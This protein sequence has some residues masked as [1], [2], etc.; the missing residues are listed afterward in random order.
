MS[1]KILWS[2]V[3]SLVMMGV[4]VC[5]SEPFLMRG[6]RPL[7]MGGA[8]VA[9]AEDASSYWNPAGL[10][11]Q[12]K[13]FD[14]EIPIYADVTGTKD[15]VKE[16]DEIANAGYYSLKQKA[17]T[18][19]YGTATIGTESVKSFFNL[20]NELDDLNK[21]GIGILINAGAG[22]NLRIKKWGLSFN[23]Y[24]MFSGAPSIDLNNISFGKTGTSSVE[25]AKDAIYALVGDGN[26]I[27]GTDTIQSKLAESL[28]KITLSSG[29]G[30]IT[31]NQAEQL[32]QYALNAGLSFD[33]VK[34]Y[35]T[36]VVEVASKAGSSTM[37]GSSTD[38]AFENNNSTLIT[39]GALIQEIIFTYPFPQ[40]RQNLYL[41]ANLKYMRA[42]IGW[43]APKIFKKD[44]EE[45]IVD[46][47]DYT[48]DSSGF[49]IDLGA[50]YDINTKLT[51]GLVIKN[52]NSPSFAYPDKAR[53][54]KY[55]IKPQ[56]RCGV[57]YKPWRGMTLSTDVDVTK[58]NTILDGF[59]SRLLSAGCEWW[60]FNFLALRG[61]L[62]KNLAESS[63]GTVFTGG[64][65][66]NLL[67][68][69]IELA[70]MM[71]SKK[72]K[73]ESGDKV[74]TNIGGSIQLSLNF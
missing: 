33:E 28:V 50:L 12:Q 61:G 3:C 34:K 48:K 10:A 31:Q 44:V 70:G 11:K 21:E 72:T 67:H 13:G 26:D 24:T 6:T 30:I 38:N 53:L 15:I 51:T 14:A 40:L 16:L 43:Y 46:V 71:S 23:S 2:I 27:Y 74:P 65:G 68:L 47:K 32:I 63:V 56:V 19:N 42:K 39:K 59:D 36:L 20:L 58:N 17:I 57:A 69:H 7:A 60:W 55:K 52:I 41:G 5:F 9:V 1:K 62:L 37:I 25:S 29:E 35:T 45:E 22:F 73:T 8:F 64:L 4:S 18:R 49:G 66:V 54:P